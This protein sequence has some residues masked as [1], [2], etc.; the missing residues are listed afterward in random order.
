MSRQLMRITPSIVAAAREYLELK[1]EGKLPAIHVAEC[2]PIPPEGVLEIWEHARFDVLR[3]K[4]SQG[5]ELFQVTVFKD[6]SFVAEHACS[7]DER[8]RGSLFDGI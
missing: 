2:Y 6:R 5:F 4:G 7:S 3:M 1:R 8:N